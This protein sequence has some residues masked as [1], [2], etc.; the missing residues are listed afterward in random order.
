MIEKWDLSNS[1]TQKYVEPG[2]Q[3]NLNFFHDFVSLLLTSASQ[4]ALQGRLAGTAHQVSLKAIVESDFF[5]QIWE[6]TIKCD[7]IS[8]RTKR[9]HFS[10]I[11][12]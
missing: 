11:S 1:R 3:K 2:E 8:A 9:S 5:F 6:S 12:N 10:F 4:L 7:I